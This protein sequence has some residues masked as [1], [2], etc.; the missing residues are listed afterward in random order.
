MR[1]P[2]AFC[3]LFGY[4]PSHDL[5]PRD[6]L[7]PLLPLSDTIGILANSAQDARLA[8][9]ALEDKAQDEDEDV[10]LEGL[11]FGKPDNHFYEDLDPEVAAWVDTALNRLQHAGI[12]LVPVS[13]PNPDDGTQLY[14]KLNREYGKFFRAH[15][16]ATLGEEHFCEL[17]SAMDDNTRLGLEAIDDLNTAEYIRLRESLETLRANAASAMRELDGWLVPS[18]PMTAMPLT[19]INGYSEAAALQLRAGRNMSMV[20]KLGYIATTTPVPRDDGGLPVGLQLVMPNGHD[21]R[22]L[23]T[24]CAIEQQ[25]GRPPRARALM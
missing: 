23:V 14:G 21:Q 4:L 6:G 11:C 24:A 20:N 16:R 15:L 18:L 7:F 19:G 8:C 17:L 2:A 10:S 9:S 3:G 13:V 12:N 5:W 1:V 25:L 22:L